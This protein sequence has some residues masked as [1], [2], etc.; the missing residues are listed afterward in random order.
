MCDDRQRVY[1]RELLAKGIASRAEIRDKSNIYL[2]ADAMVGIG[3][4]G[5]A[6]GC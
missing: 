4:E 5:W 2:M 1:L 3:F 6:N